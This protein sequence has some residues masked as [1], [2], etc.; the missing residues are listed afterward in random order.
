VEAFSEE[1]T[2][3]FDSALRM[4]GLWASGRTQSNTKPPDIAAEIS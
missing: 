1:R 2:E 4:R 3:N